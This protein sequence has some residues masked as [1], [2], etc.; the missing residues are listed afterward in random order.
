MTA[1]SLA[2]AAAARAQHVRQRAD[3]PSQR[4]CAEHAAARAAALVPARIELRAAD[5]DGGL[6]EFN[7]YATVY[8]HG[9]EMWDYYGPYTEIVSAG[10]GAESLARGDLDVPLV[11]QHNQLRRIA[12]TTNGSLELTEDDNGL[13]VHAPSLDPADHDVAY[14]APKLR[15]GL[16]DEMS[17]AFRI[18]SGQWSP[19]YTE[20]R[21]NRYD[22]HRGDVAIVGYGA[23]PATEA[24]LRTA[25]APSSRARALLEIALAR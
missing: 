16:I 25:A 12:R 6:L 4:R 10:A 7:G 5:G 3:R 14:I 1:T 9:Y 19:D 21:I 23:N 18:S 11:L 8:E 20:Y 24:T 22:I 2:A 15:A 17:F 13:S